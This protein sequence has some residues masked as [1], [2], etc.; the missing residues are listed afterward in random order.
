MI[1][2]ENVN[3]SFGKLDVLKNI[4]LTINQGEVVGIIGP[5]GSG[6]STL[7][8][9]II[10]L[11]KISSGKIT[12]E[13]E[14]LDDKNNNTTKALISPKKEASILS[15]LGIVFQRFNLFPHL[16]VRDN[17]TLAPRRV[18]KMSRA[19]DSNVSNGSDAT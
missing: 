13:D 19:E 6:K 11:E 17:V 10:H 15:K 4:N 12:I 9:C 2:I 7:L 5:S 1:K 14:I 3:K 16:S 18:R 8:R